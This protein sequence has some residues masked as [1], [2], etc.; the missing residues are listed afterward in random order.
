MSEISTRDNTRLLDAAKKIY[1]HKLEIIF[2]FKTL[3]EQVDD[4][5]I[6]NLLVQVS[7]EEETI[8]EMWVNRIIDQGGQVDINGFFGNMKPKILF[9]ILGTKGFFKWVLEEEEAGIKEL[10]LQAELIQENVQSETWS[11]YAADEQRHL[12]RIRTEIFGMDLWDIQGTSGERATAALFSGYYSGLLSTLSF[13]TGMFGARTGINIIFISGLASI[14]SGS[15]ARAGGAYQKHHSE[16]EILTRESKKISINRNTGDE[17]RKQLLEFYYSQ[18]FSDEEATSFI[19][20]INVDRPSN[21]ENAIDNI[22]LSSTQFGN[23]VKIGINS[24]R[25]FAIAAIIPILPFLV[26]SLELENALIISAC[27]TMLCLFIVGAAKSIFTRKNWYKSGF[28]VVVFGVITSAITYTIGT[29][30]SLIL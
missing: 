6:K 19:D 13:I 9:R 29:L 15:I 20:S 22:G 14:F 23:S 4:E 17:D 26:R 1:E 7:S 11:R 27:G 10:A 18:G 30:V 2:G 28:E 5:I 16:M 3:A 25:N 24:G 21:I 12:H 8:V